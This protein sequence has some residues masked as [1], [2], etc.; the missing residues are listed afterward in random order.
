[1]KNH[2]H[3][4]PDTTTT[5][6]RTS[7]TLRTNNNKNKN[8]RPLPRYT[9]GYK[10]KTCQALTPAVLKRRRVQKRIQGG[11]DSNGSSSSQLRTDGSPQCGQ[12]SATT[13]SRQQEQSSKLLSDKKYGTV[14]V[15]GLRITVLLLLVLTM[16]FLSIGMY[17]YTRLEEQ[18]NFESAFEVD[19]L[20][21][22]ERF[23]EAVEYKL[24]AMNTLSTTF[25]SYAQHTNQT[26]PNGT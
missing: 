26:F 24:G 3:P 15:Q 20:R 22:V 7:R 2:D 14:W 13:S 9:A 25:T 10:K 21:I 1:M 16:V 23:H 5:T 19:A 17:F 4:D 18:N 12:T 11:T 8:L 6:T